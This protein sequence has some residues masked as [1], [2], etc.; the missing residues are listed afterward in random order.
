MALSIPL[1]SAVW[2][3]YLGRYSFI[4]NSDRDIRCRDGDV[5]L[6]YDQSVTDC[7][8][9]DNPLDYVKEYFRPIVVYREHS[10]PPFVN[11]VVGYI[12]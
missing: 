7:G 9:F 10:L 12:G 6:V 11:G 5:F 3:E 4:G 8:A 2:G 1:E